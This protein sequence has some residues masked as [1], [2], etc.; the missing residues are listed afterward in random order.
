VAE[1]DQRIVPIDVDAQAAGK[2]LGVST[3]AVRAAAYRG[4]LSSHHIGS[5]LRF[6]PS[7][8]LPERKPITSSRHE[9]GRPVRA[10][11]KLDGCESMT[12]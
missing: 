3:V 5:R 7:E 10:E 1:H 6:R 11:I 12:A 9:S 2:L 4:T 8:L